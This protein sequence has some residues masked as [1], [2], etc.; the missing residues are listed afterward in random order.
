MRQIIVFFGA[1]MLS[2]YTYAQYRCTINGQRVYSDQ[3]C[4]V[5]A[6]HVGKMQD[7][8]TDDQR[9]QR[10]RLSAKEMR[11]G[12]GVD[13]KRNAEYAERDARWQQKM[14]AEAAADRDRKERCVDLQRQ[15]TSDRRAVALYQDA[16]FQKSLTEREAE[17]R[18]NQERYDREC[19]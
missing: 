16:G 10:A 14:A 13:A 7:R 17:R 1:L 5:N 3:P 11:E 19:R 4:A 8:V 6:E 15:L 12:R 2:A 18:A 9:R